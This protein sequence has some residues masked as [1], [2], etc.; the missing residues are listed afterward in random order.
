MKIFLISDEA[1]HPREVELA[2]AALSLGVESYHLRK[3]HWGARKIRAYLNQFDFQQR[4][5]IAVHTQSEL[6]FEI[7]IARVHLK[8]HQVSLKQK[9]QTIRNPEVFS[10]SVHSLV[11]VSECYGDFDYLFMS[12]VFPSISKPGHIPM[13]SHAEFKSLVQGLKV[14]PQDK[15]LSLLKKFRPTQFVA[16]G[17]VSHENI[18]QVKD[19]GFEGVA[20]L[21]SFWRSTDPIASLREIQ[22]KCLELESTQG[23][24]GG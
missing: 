4:Q 17:G 19:L 15:E 9:F 1:D 11:E 16:L 5:R 6:L 20:I 10:H 23:A 13:W 18:S 7:Q 3:P 2:K 24:M 8:S 12:P 22:A 14:S 21:G